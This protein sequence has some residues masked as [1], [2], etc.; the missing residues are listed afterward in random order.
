MERRGRYRLTGIS[1]VLNA[2][3]LELK[4]GRQLN[5]PDAMER[6]RQWRQLTW[7]SY[8]CKLRLFAD[9]AKERERRWRRSVLTVRE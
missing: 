4:M 7:A 6:D 1:T 8:R 9:S 2:E 3:G 5:V